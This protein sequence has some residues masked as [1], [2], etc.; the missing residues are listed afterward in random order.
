MHVL[1]LICGSEF[2]LKRD[3][4]IKKKTC[5]TAMTCKMTD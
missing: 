1:D 3:T 5:T 2:G 4:A